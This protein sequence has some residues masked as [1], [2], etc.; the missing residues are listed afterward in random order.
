[1]VDNVKIY[2]LHEG[3]INLLHHIIRNIRL[4]CN[5]SAHV[6]HFPSG[7]IT[8]FLK[9]CYVIAMAWFRVH[10]GLFLS[11]GSCD[12]SDNSSTCPSARGDTGSVSVGS[13]VWPMAREVL[14][15][16]SSG[17]CVESS[18]ALEPGWKF[19]K[20]LGPLIGVLV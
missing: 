12:W 4:F 11:L 20:P 17:P 15:R 13:C 5:G 3:I 7:E 9:V 10:V 8:K 16:S 2:I 1:M 14:I 18:C 19:A 6:P